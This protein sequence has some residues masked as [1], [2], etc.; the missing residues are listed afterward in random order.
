MKEFKRCADTI[1]RRREMTG[2]AVT[3]SRSGVTRVGLFKEGTY[4]LN[5]AQMQASLVRDERMIF[6]VDIS[7]VCVCVCARMMATG[8]QLCKIAELGDVHSVVEDRIDVD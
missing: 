3:W 1:R 8:E 6:M 7:C 4:R 2:V 5:V